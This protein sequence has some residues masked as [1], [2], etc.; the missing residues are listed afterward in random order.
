[1]S[2]Q[3]S[4][5]VLGLGRFGL[6]VVKTLSEKN[7]NVLACDKMENRTQEVAS[8]ATHTIQADI[9][10]EK[11]LKSLGLGNYDVVII[12]MGTEFE[13]ALIAAMVAVEEGVQYVVA[14]AG[15]ERQKKILKS[16]GVHEVVFPEYEMGVKLANRLTGINLLDAL[17][18]SEMYTLAEINPQPRWVGKSIREC[19]IRNKHGLTILAVVRAGRVE[20]PVSPD[21]V[22][23]PND[24]LVTL[25]SKP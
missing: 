18:D 8:F 14:K 12:A 7:V 19:D 17:G 22:F 11:V 4:Y 15:G 10:D 25:Q 21:W 9:S 13:A 23:E 3:K 1:M 24:L 6:S 5:A 2:K 16:I 20:V